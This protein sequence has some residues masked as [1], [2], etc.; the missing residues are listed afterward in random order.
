MDFFISLLLS[1]LNLRS[2]TAL[3]FNV[4]IYLNTENVQIEP[5][6][7]NSLLTSSAVSLYSIILYKRG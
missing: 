7:D 4:F 1:D 3:I 6:Y 2:S 5:F